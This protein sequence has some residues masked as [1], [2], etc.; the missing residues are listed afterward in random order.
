MHILCCGDVWLVTGSG[1]AVLC[2]RVYVCVC[3]PAVSMK[4][5]D[6]DVQNPGTCVLHSKVAVFSL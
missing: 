5:S 1:N 6:A 4:H 3:V 2:L